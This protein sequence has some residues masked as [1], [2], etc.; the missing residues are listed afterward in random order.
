MTK[1]NAR[2]WRLYNQ[3]KARG[4]VW[5]KQRELAELLPDLYP[6]E[7]VQSFHDSAARLLMTK[8]IQALNKSASI[9]KIIISSARGVKVANEAEAWAFIESKYS[10]AFKGLEAARRM[11]SKAGLDGQAR[12]VF[13]AERPIIQAFLEETPTRLICSNTAS[14]C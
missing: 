3:L 10:A 6:C 13:G 7:G 14:F 5:T 11:E 9:Q 1:L 8:D 4:D 2:Q 12:L